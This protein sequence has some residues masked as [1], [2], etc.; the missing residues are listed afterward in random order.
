[1]GQ[2]R[3]REPAPRQGQEARRRRRGLTRSAGSAVLPADARFPRERLAQVLWVGSVAL[4]LPVSVRL[5]AP[6]F[7]AARAAARLQADDDFFP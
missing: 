7:G 2:H 6:G 5:K 4:G 1:G 3:R